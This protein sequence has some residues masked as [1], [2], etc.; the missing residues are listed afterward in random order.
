MVPPIAAGT[1]VIEGSY[2]PRQPEPT[3]FLIPFLRFEYADQA[4]V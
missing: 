3:N 4:N 1:D 2:H